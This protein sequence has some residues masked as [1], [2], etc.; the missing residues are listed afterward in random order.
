MKVITDVSYTRNSPCV[1]ALG[2]FDGVHLGHASVISAAKEK[3]NALGIPLCVWSF[4]EPPKR[5]Y[6]PNST[7]LLTDS[8]TKRRLIKELGVDIYISISFDEKIAAITPEEFFDVILLNNLRAACVVCGFNFTFGKGGKG[9]KHTLEN[10]CKSKNIEFISVPS[11]CVDGAGVSSSRIRSCLSEGDVRSVAA[12]LGRPYS[13]N[14][15]VIDGK[16]LGRALGF[17]TINQ[18]V[19]NGMCIPRNGVYLARV[20]FDGLSYYAITN[21]GAQPTVGGNDV[22]SESHIFDFSGDIY[23]KEVTV[24]FLKFIRPVKKFSSLDEL[25]NQVNI[26]IETARKLIK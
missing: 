24:E 21:I 11:V 1:V 3:A 19:K 2:C 5:F 25:K 10:L 8:E 20:H 12:L 23:G 15:E 22:I 26:D 7:P 16:H 13:I 17:P 6:N 18:K 9:N 4:A 14:S